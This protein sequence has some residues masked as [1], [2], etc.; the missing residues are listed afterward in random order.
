ME[1]ARVDQLPSIFCLEMI[2]IELR[3]SSFSVSIGQYGSK[4]NWIKDNKEIGDTHSK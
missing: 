3:A 2:L 4:N 1:I